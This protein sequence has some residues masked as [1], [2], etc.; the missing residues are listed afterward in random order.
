MLLKN[1]ICGGSLPRSPLGELTVPSPRTPSPLLTFGLEFGP[2]GLNSG[3]PPRQIPGC[4]YAEMKLKL[5]GKV[6][7]ETAVYVLQRIR[8]WQKVRWIRRLTL[9]GKVSSTGWHALRYVLYVLLYFILNPTNTA[10]ILSRDEI[11][12]PS[13]QDMQAAFYKMCRLQSF[14]IHQLHVLNN[15]VKNN[16]YLT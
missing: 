14:L 13:S 7:T 3:A 15:K 16:C 5:I 4:A 2:S 8:Q 6:T 12:Q 10:Y 9:T 11:E 1:N